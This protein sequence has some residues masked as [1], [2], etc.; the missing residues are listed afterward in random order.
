MEMFFWKQQ[1]MLSMN[2]S[3]V[4][5]VVQLDVL[6]VEELGEASVV[7][8]V[9]MH[10]IDSVSSGVRLYGSMNVVSKRLK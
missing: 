6:H 2:N 10:E 5:R 3:H 7:V 8:V 1:L 4:R 9:V